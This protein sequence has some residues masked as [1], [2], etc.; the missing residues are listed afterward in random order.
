MGHMC[1]CV[2][3]LCVICVVLWYGGL[4]VCMCGMGCVYVGV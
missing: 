2:L 3:C 4:S 1:T